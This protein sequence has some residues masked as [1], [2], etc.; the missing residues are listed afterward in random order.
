MTETEE[1]Q[2]PKAAYGFQSYENLQIWVRSMVLVQDCYHLCEQLPKSED[3]ILASQ[4]KRA[5]ISIP[6]NISEGWARKSNK[7]FLNHLKIAFGSLHE[8]LT[9]IQIINKLYNLETAKLK[10]DFTELSKML[11]GFI[12]YLESKIKN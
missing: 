4:L 5:S 11:N 3:F 2:D 12:K 9:Q 1:I 10:N 7:A 8:C 6:S